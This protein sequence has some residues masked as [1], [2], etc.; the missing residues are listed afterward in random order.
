LFVGLDLMV[1][2]SLLHCYHLTWSAARRLTLRLKTSRVC[3]RPSQW[4][5]HWSA[6]LRIS[7]PPAA[8]S[9]VCAGCLPFLNWDAWLY[10]HF[11]A[12][13]WITY[14]VNHRWRSSSV[15]HTGETLLWVA[16]AANAMCWSR[17]SEWF[18]LVKPAKTNYSLPVL[19]MGMWRYIHLALWWTI[20]LPL[21]QYSPYVYIH[22][23]WLT[24]S[25]LQ[26][27][28]IDC[29]WRSEMTDV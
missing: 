17:G 21:Q 8:T 2:S 28:E 11:R 25:F 12:F 20:W 18:A 7:Y 27:H 19:L 1:P 23:K 24:P 26:C 6:L 5:A 15:C 14:N 3:L 29:H 13:N 4:G 16:S 9:A 10:V 22:D